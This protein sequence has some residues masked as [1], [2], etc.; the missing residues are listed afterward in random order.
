MVHISL[1]RRASCIPGFISYDLSSRSQSD[2]V[3][4]ETTLYGYTTLPF[5]KVIETLSVYSMT[6]TLLLDIV[7]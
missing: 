2:P 5:E 3:T 4:F 1:V 6:V 7:A